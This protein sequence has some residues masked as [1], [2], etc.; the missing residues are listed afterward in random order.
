MI[1]GSIR[2]LGYSFR[3]SFAV[4]TAANRYEVEALGKYKWQEKALPSL[5]YDVE[6]SSPTGTHNVYNSFMGLT[7]S[8]IFN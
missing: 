4:H 1:N 7:F 3:F 8:F 2:A 5:P 6:V